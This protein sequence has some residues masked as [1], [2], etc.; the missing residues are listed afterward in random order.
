MF[1][2]SNSESWRTP[3]SRWPGRY[4]KAVRTQT[5]KLL[6]MINRDRHL[7]FH[8]VLFIWLVIELAHETTDFPTIPCHFRAF[9]IRPCCPL[10]TPRVWPRR[11][12]VAQHKRARLLFLHWLWTTMAFLAGTWASPTRMDASA[13]VARLGSCATQMALEN[14]CFWAFYSLASPLWKFQT[15]PAD[16]GTKEAGRTRRALVIPGTRPKPKPRLAHAAAARAQTP[17]VERNTQQGNGDDPRTKWRGEAWH[18]Q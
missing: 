10:S 13:L 7:F 15:R 11:L 5:R 2:I 14:C 3:T 1:P 6:A 16:G 12:C 17:I 4:I 9:G 18:R 8:Q